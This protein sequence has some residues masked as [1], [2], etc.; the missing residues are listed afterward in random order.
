MTVEQLKEIVS[1]EIDKKFNALIDG[2]NLKSEQMLCQ[3]AF[4]KQYMSHLVGDMGVSHSVFRNFLRSILP[5]TLIG[6]GYDGDLVAIGKDDDGDLHTLPQAS[7]LFVR[8]VVAA[9]SIASK[10]V[11]GTIDKT[12]LDKKVV[13]VEDEKTFYYSEMNASVVDLELLVDTDIYI[14]GEYTLRKIIA[15][16]DI[17]AEWLIRIGRD[18]YEKE[19]DSLSKLYTK[20]ELQNKF[21]LIE[22]RLTSLEQA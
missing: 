13:Y 10:G 18:Y 14:V 2:L 16:A 20:E 7:Q 1:S 6:V 3:T 17:P 22:D 9:R 12:S 19:G 8:G 4:E 11:M 5:I 15:L 21:Q